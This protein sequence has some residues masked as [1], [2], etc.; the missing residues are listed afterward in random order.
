MAVVLD[1]PGCSLQENILGQPG[2]PEV[3]LD[4][5]VCTSLGCLADWYFFWVFLS[6]VARKKQCC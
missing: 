4:G 2:N 6:I 5:S 3:T 1:S